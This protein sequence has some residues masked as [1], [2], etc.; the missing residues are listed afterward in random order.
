MDAS[1]WVL[2]SEAR[3]TPTVSPSHLWLSCVGGAGWTG[4]RLQRRL[5]NG[6]GTDGTRC[7][8]GRWL[9]HG[10]GH[11]TR[12]RFERGPGRQIWHRIRLGLRRLFGSWR[13]IRTISRYLS[14]PTALLAINRR[15]LG[16]SSLI[17][18][19]PSLSSSGEPCTLAPGP[20]TFSSGHLSSS[21]G[22]PSP[23]RSVMPQLRSAGG[24][25]LLE[26]TASS[27][28]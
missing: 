1:G 27:I 13:G 14:A 26:Q 12:S 21:S 23:S 18:G 17:S 4:R 8:S 10:Q 2:A 16:Q 28:H 19:M 15:V 6:T 22:W 20:P 7:Q 5:W 3:A 9:R 25:E 24:S 11:R